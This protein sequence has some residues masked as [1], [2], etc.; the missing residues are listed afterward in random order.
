MAVPDLGST[1]GLGDRRMAKV[2][3]WLTSH[4][5]APFQVGA[6]PYLTWTGPKGPVP[7]APTTLAGSHIPGTCAKAMPELRGA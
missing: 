3:D 6:G 5:M 4:G 7:P 2:T 1:G